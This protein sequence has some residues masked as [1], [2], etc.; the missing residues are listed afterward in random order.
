VQ[1]S[2]RSIA[3][4]LLLSVV[5]AVALLAAL[6]P[7]LRTIPENLF[8]PAWALGG[9]L[10]TLVPYHLLRAGRWY[11]LVRPLGDVSWRGATLVSLAGYMW[12]AVLP[13]RLGELARPLFLTQHAGVATR[14]ALGSVAIERVVDG[15]VVCGLFFAALAVGGQPSGFELF[16]WL[17]E[18]MVAVIA[19]FAAAL[20]VLIGMAVR[21]TFAGRIVRATFG[22]FAPRLAAR[23]ADLVTGIAEGLAALPSARAL[24]TF[25]GLTLAY[26]LVN[27]IGMWWLARGCGLELHLIEIMAVLS[28]M[29]V[30]L[31]APGGPGQLGV[32]QTGVAI[33]L[34]MFVSAETV[35][36]HGSTFAFYLYVC[37]ISTIALVGVWA[38]ARLRLDWRAVFRLRDPETPHTPGPP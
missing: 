38:Q 12:I 3:L 13:L 16:D 34:G 29:N 1:R 35:Q 4:R 27:A 10:L 23:I 26:W 28:V 24:A 25:L 5:L 22:R 9:Y 36:R 21:P 31:Q 20:V 8:V 6:A 32:F 30:V 19:A 2:T 15:L 33:G 18:L 14:R 17:H 7:H 37:Q 11:V